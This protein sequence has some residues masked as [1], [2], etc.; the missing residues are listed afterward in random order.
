MLS[1]RPSPEK[2]SFADHCFINDGVIVEFRVLRS[3]LQSGPAVFRDESQAAAY[4]KKVNRTYERIE[5]P[6]KVRVSWN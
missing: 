1:N 5:Y 2:I 3:W 4:A 6:R